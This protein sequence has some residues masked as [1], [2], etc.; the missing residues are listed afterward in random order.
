[1]EHRLT[2]LNWAMSRRLVTKAE[3][4]H[5]EILSRDKKRLIL[6]Y[7]KSTKQVLRTRVNMRVVNSFLIM[8]IM[9]K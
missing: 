4:T 8:M 5:Q 9:K 1:M 2:E 6:P 3:E 7:K